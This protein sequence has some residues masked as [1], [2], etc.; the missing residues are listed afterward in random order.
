MQSSTRFHLFR[1]C[2]L[3]LLVALAITVLMPAQEPVSGP[4]SISKL[5]PGVL[6]VIDPVLEEAETVS[7][8]SFSQIRRDMAFAE[9]SPEFAADSRRLFNRAARAKLRRPVWGLEFTFKPFRLVHVD[10]PQLTGKAQRKAIWYMVY[11]IRY[12]GSEI[13]P[14][15]DQTVAGTSTFTRFLPERRDVDARRFVPQFVLRN[16]STGVEYLE[17]VI[18]AAIDDIQRRERLDVLYNTVEIPGV[19][20]PVSNQKTGKGVWGVVTWEDIDPRTDFFS[21]YVQGLTNAYRFRDSAVA[22]QRG[23]LEFK[24]LQ[25]NFHRPGDTVREHEREIRYGIPDNPI[26][27]RI[28]HVIEAGDS[29]SALAKR[30]LGEETRAGDIFDNNRNILVTPD[31]LPE[32]QLLR[33]PTVDFDDLEPNSDVATELY[34]IRQH[35]LFTI[36]GV[37]KQVPHLWIYRLGTLE[38][39]PSAQ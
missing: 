16:H 23:L 15:M 1:A 35:Q 24:T 18:P 27:T 5:G 37:D 8:I 33:I 26:Q 31:R 30:Y 9:W 2:T 12:L 25:L 38:A 32:G 36:Y 13:H 19:K 20:I 21:I 4:R 14:K 3:S 28:T 7:R 11:R 34:S 29:L 39:K 17:R 10:I 6:T 22:E